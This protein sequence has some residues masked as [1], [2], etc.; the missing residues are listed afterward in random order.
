MTELAE[1]GL[2]PEQWGGDTIVTKISAKNNIGIDE[3]LDNILLVAEMQ[4]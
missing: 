1:H 3:L 4:E 2:T